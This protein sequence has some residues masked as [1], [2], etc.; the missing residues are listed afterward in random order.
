[1]IYDEKRM[2]NK[3]MEGAIRFLLDFYKPLCMKAPSIGS[4]KNAVYF[5]AKCNV[6]VSFFLII[7][8]DYRALRSAVKNN[9]MQAS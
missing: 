4:I 1:M 8:Q 7:A 9:R 6:T 3:F 5:S 2:R